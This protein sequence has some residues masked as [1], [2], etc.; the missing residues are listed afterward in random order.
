[1]HL[2]APGRA[3]EADT[4]AIFQP[5]QIGGLTLK[6]RLLRSSISGRIDNYD[7]SGTPARVNF[8]ERFAKGGVA[9]IISSHVPIAPA[10]RVLPHYAMIDRNERITFWRT[11][12][13]RVHQHD[14]KFILQ[15]SHSGRQ[16]DIGGVE[17]LGR[18]PDGV[19][20]KPDYFNGLASRVM[21][22]K[23]I[24]R[25]VELFA[26]A[27][28]R[29]RAARLDGIEL[30]SA[31]GYL[32]TQ[33]L[34]SAINDRKDRYGGGLENRSRFLLEVIDAIQR[35]VG[36]D[37]PLLVKVTGHDYHNAAGLWPR[38]DGNGI[39]DAIKIA[40]WVESAGVHAIHVSTG[41]MFP[42]PMNPAGPM[43]VDVGKIT[44]QN[45]IGSGRWTFRNF[46]GFRY[47]GWFVRWLWSRKQP[48][49]RP[50]GTIDPQKLE[51]FAAADAKAIRAKVKIPVL[52]TGGFQTAHGIGKLLRDGSCDAVTIARSLLANPSLPRELAEGWDGPKDPPCTYCNK[53]LLHVVEHPLGCYDES[54][55]EGRGGREE[56]LR[57]VFEIFTDYQEN[58]RPAQL[59]DSSTVETSSS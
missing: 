8:E 18:L 21:S 54:R 47:F 43:A 27:A 29:V 1:M 15:L 53:C 39:E 44:Y 46:M 30:H 12:G 28:E 2:Q 42:H 32:F 57:Q 17:N 35:R 49:W 23:D 55:Y 19:T 41:N 7:G 9:A 3:E 26:A 4:Q 48:F 14:C 40:Q 33:F 5:L 13:E 31:N 10:A 38:P 56:M 25:V 6:N 51:G 16:Q 37:F 58:H 24:A 50:D 22:E 45:L 34:S 59:E 11:V 20:A 52:V 36:R